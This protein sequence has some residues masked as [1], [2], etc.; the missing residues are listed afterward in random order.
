M[1]IKERMTPNPITIQDDVPISELVSLMRE[2]SIKKV[3][4]MHKDQLVGIV[5]HG[6]VQRVSPSA[7]TSLSV[8]EINYLLSKT[9]VRDA[10]SKTVFTTTPDSYVEDA[11]VIMRYNH[12]NAL[13]VVDEK[14]KLVGIVTESDLFDALISMMGGRTSGHRFVIEAEDVPGTIGK[15]GD[16]IASRGININHFACWNSNGGKY[17]LLV[18]IGMETDAEKAKAAL[19]GEGFAIKSFSSR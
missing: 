4:V 9:R 13:C 8:F 3:P 18:K 6:D 15:L 16:A 19:E 1:Y 14:G 10:M 7:A 17:E 5:T 12:I 11:A 2:K